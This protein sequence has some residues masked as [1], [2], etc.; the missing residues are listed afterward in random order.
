MPDGQAGEKLRAGETRGG[1]K[2]K[3]NR[4]VKHVSP[5]EIGG[6]LLWVQSGSGEKGE[7]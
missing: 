2:R 6:N 3:R 4:G 7:M 5:F 1:V